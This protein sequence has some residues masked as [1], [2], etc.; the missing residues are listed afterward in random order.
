[1]CLSLLAFLPAFGAGVFTVYRVLGRHSSA[2]THTVCMPH[3]KYLHVS[4]YQQQLASVSVCSPGSAVATSLC[5]DQI[6]VHCCFI[7]WLQCVK[8]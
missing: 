4:V 6:S 2:S 8:Y 1:M 3:V 7:V 5:Y